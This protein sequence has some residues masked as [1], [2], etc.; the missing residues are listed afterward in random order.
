M[1]ARNFADLFEAAYHPRPNKIS[2][3][4]LRDLIRWALFTILQQECK[5]QILTTPS[6]LIDNDP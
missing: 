6:L 4:R 5:I 1:N 2:N 3:K